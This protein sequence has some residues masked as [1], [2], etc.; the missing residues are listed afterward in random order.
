[1]KWTLG[2]RQM[3]L[4]YGL[5]GSQPFGQAAGGSGIAFAQATN[6]VYGIG[7]HAA[8]ELNRRLGDSGFGAL[9]PD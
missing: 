9:Y 3:F 1:M 2:L 7:P 5:Q 6:N 8:L 4:F